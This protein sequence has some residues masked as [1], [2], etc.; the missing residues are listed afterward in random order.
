MRASLLLLLMSLACRMAS[1]SYIEA[2]RRLRDDLFANYDRRV[3]PVQQST[4][5]TEVVFH[6][7][8]HDVDLMNYDMLRVETWTYWEWKDELLKWDPNRYEG[9]KELSMGA[10]KIWMPELVHLSRGQVGNALEPMM[11]KG[12][13]CRVTSD[14]DVSCMVDAEY[15]TYCGVDLA[16]WPYDT[17]TCFLKFINWL[18]L[19]DEVSIKLRNGTG[20]SIKEV[21]TQRNWELVNVRSEQIPRQNDDRKGFRKID[22]YFDFRR[23]SEG[24]A[25]TAVTPAIV[26]SLGTLSTLLVPPWEAERFS[27]LLSLMAAQCLALADLYHNFSFVITVPRVVLLY[28]DSLV[29]AAAALVLAVVMRALIHSEVE[30]PSCVAALLDQVPTW[31][32]GLSLLAQPREELGGRKQSRG[33]A[34]W[35]QLAT[36]VD[37]CFFCAS[38]LAVLVLLASLVP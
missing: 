16:K 9:I 31:P 35:R 25:A 2:V 10:N 22:F 37:R 19:D 13:M 24:Y 17:Q 27:V 34:V 11:P 1:A 3:R 12:G 21:K 15:E 36:L 28:R 23:H 18:D 14:G 30:A 7:D 8:I 32:Y 4:T 38:C 6:M 26:L 20:F 29:L 5:I 33:A